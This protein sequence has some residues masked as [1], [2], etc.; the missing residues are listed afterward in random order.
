MRRLVESLVLDGLADVHTASDAA[1]MSSRTFQRR[2]A[3]CALTYSRL[4]QEARTVL[5]ERWLLDA[6]RT[7]SDVA[8]SLGCT[9]PARFTRAFRRLNGMPPSVFAARRT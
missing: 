9:D 6:G 2:L 8:H 5:A 3:E 1:R 4:V 7:V